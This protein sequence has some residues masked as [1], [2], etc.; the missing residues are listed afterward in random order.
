MKIFSQ[1]SGGDR[2]DS[3]SV[4]SFPRGIPGFEEH[5]SFKLTLQDDSFQVYK[6]ESMVDSSVAFWVAQPSAFNINYCFVLMQAE[7]D[8]LQIENP[9][10][11]LILLIL[12]KD[13]DNRLLIKGA[14]NSPLL[15]NRTKNVGLQKLLVYLD[16]AIVMESPNTSVLS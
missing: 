11:L 7:Q 8:C 5:T 4:L 1:S 12:Q 13:A 2:I 16:Q 15:I 6:L 14:V 9:D 10:E 3:G